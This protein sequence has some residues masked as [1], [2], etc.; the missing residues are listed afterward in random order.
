LAVKGRTLGPR[1]LARGADDAIGAVQAQ[2]S[3]ATPAPMTV[4]LFPQ[5]VPIEDAKAEHGVQGRERPVP[6]K[7]PAQVTRSA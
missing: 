1:N 2:L 5:L 7:Q 4:R 3:H 6:R